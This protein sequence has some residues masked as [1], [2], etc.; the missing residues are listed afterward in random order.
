MPWST[1]DHWA[2]RLAATN[3]PIRA[4]EL[5]STLEMAAIPEASRAFDSESE[6][7]AAEKAG[8]RLVVRGDPDYPALLERIYDPPLVL[9]V[10]G[11]IP[12]RAHIAFVGSRNASQHGLRMARRLAGDAA[13]R[14]ACVVSGLARGIDGAAHAGALDAGGDT[15]AVLAT[16]VVRTYPPEHAA[17]ADRIVAAG[18]GVLS[19]MPSSTP[20]SRD[21]WPRRN[22]IISGLSWATVVVEG[23]DNSGSLITA[24]HAL[25]QGRELMAVPGPADAPNSYIPHR[26]ISEGAKLVTKVDHIV[27]SLT[28]EALPLLDPLWRA[29]EAAAPQAVATTGEEARILA[30]LGSDALSLDELMV[31]SGL[32]TTAISSI[33]FGLEMK[34]RIILL[35]GQRYAQK[36]R[37]QEAR[38][39]RQGS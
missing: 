12:S 4:F 39:G 19:E 14:G 10:R 18:G 28:E 23:A 37:R 36:A 1:R 7:K 3:A 9:F 35:P 8:A 16:G 11:R 6:E 20:A 2:V 34:N 22:R 5:L 30:L 33:M 25:D 15:L 21:L 32:D 26:L 17:L 38:Q 29:A 24:N 31:L 13:V 27:E